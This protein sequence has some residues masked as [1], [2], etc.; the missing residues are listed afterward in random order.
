MRTQRLDMKALAERV[1]QELESHRSGRN[2]EFRLREL[3]AC[4][5]DPAA[6]H[7]VLQ[8]LMTNAIKF[9]RG[10]DPAIIEMGGE[11]SGAENIYFVKDNGA[12]FDT[13]HADKLFGIFQRLHGVK[14]F[15][16]TGVGLA[17]VKCF[18]GKLG[19]RVWAQSKP[20]EGATFWFS[21]PSACRQARQALTARSP[22]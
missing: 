18:V 22:R 6:V 15:E 17:V 9:T 20:G 19:G 4:V 13:A 16:G 21:L 7:Q 14:E 1:W 12:G 11:A 5:G 2:I 3:P 8:N 10:R